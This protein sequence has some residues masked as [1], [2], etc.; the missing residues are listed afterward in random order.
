MKSFMYLWGS[1]IKSLSL[2]II[3]IF[4]VYMAAEMIVLNDRYSEL[5]RDVGI[6]KLIY[7]LAVVSA[8][9]IMVILLITSFII[10]VITFPYS[11]R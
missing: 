11:R 5:L 9:F 4:Y 3:G 6:W 2:L 7:G 8:M 1:N 10:T